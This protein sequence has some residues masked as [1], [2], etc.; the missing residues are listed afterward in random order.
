M[1]PLIYFLLAL[2]LTGVPLAAQ[3]GQNPPAQQK[4]AQPVPPNT[5]AMETLGKVG[6]TNYLWTNGRAW[7]S[8]PDNAKI[9]LVA[10]IEQ[11]I[12]LSVRE[13]WKVMPKHE[14]QELVKT[15]ARLTVGGFTFRELAVDIDGLYLDQANLGIPIVDAYE[16]AL[17]ELKKAPKRRL[18][19]FLDQLR[20]AYHL[21]NPPNPE[22]KH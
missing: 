9:A 10:G 4:T 17:L 5:R 21:P 13:N 3:S 20:K 22:Q 7:M 2:L 6:D 12:I 8:L 19:H 11:G 14:Q 18:R 15:A 1:R 16:Y